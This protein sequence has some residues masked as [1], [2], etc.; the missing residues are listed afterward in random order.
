MK[1]Y[2]LVAASTDPPYTSTGTPLTSKFDD[3]ALHEASV[4]VSV[5]D[6]AVEMTHANDADQSHHVSANPPGKY[7]SEIIC[8]VNLGFLIV[9]EYDQGEAVTTT[10]FSRNTRADETNL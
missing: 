2:I 1:Y 6:P 7:C 8:T 10:T 9:T 5:K 3:S 4:V